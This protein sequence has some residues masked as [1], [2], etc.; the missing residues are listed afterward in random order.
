MPLCLWATG[1]RVNVARIVFWQS[2]SPPLS[3]P[4]VYFRAGERG[5]NAV[6]F[7]RVCVTATAPPSVT[8]HGCRVRGYRINGFQSARICHAARVDL[9]AAGVVA[10]KVG[11][12]FP[13]RRDRAQIVRVAAVLFG[14]TLHP[15]DPMTCAFSGACLGMYARYVRLYRKGGKNPFLT[16]GPYRSF[17]RMYGDFGKFG[18]LSPRVQ[19][20]CSPS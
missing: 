11:G 3:L 17:Y 7:D 16:A 20:R 2:A 1:S 18:S 8:A 5:P 12:P 6:I 10:S 14:V 4:R 9:E 13:G 15:R 19:G